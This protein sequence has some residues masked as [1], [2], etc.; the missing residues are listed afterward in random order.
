MSKDIKTAKLQFISWTVLFI[1][2]VL[3]Q[4]ADSKINDYQNFLNKKLLLSSN[5][6]QVHLGEEFKTQEATFLQFITLNEKLK[7]HLINQIVKDN[8]GNFLHDQKIDSEIQRLNKGEITLREYFSIMVSVHKEKS[9][10][11]LNNYN[12]GMVDIKK[13]MKSGTVW[14]PIKTYALFP[15]Q[16]FCVLYLGF[17]YF[18]AL[19]ESINR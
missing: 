3:V 19:K 7:R 13:L 1:S 18:I 15:L 4:F 6:L 8:K 11:H 16:V 5:I 9:K 17:G 2:T 12:N 14:E 10:H